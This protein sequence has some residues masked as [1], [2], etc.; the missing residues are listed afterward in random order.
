[1]MRPRSA[2]LLYKNN[3]KIKRVVNIISVDVAKKLAII[4]LSALSRKYFT[5]MHNTMNETE[6]L[7]NHTQAKLQHSN[8]NIYMFSNA[9]QWDQLKRW[10]LIRLKRM[11]EIVL[12]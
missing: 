12:I 1:M 9:I 5:F 4:S 10:N 11:H 2:C 7:N 8:I 6:I 3:A